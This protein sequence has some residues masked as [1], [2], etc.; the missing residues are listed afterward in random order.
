MYYDQ[1]NLQQ[2]ELHMKKRLYPDETSN[3]K[4]FLLNLLILADAFEEPY[5][6]INFLPRNPRPTLKGI[7]HY[8]LTPS[9]QIGYVYLVSAADVNEHFQSYQ[10]I[11]FIVIGEVDVSLF[12]GSSSLIVLENNCSIVDV[13]DYT[14]H[15]F[16]VYN[17]WDL[18]LQKAMVSETPLDDMLKSSLEIFQNPMFIHDTEFYILA[19]PKNVEGMTVWSVDSRTGRYMV[20][21]NVINDLKIDNEYLNTLKMRHVDMFSANQR[22]YRILYCNLWNGTRYEGRICINELQSVIKHGDYLA[23]EYLS[24]MVISCIA[25]R[26][27]FWM[28]LGHDVEQIC[29][30]ILSRQISEER[31]IRR[32][33]RFLDW[34]LEDTYLVIKLGNEHTEMD[35]RFTASAFGHIESQVSA[36]H[37]F[38]YQEGIVV[39]VNLTVSK[40]TPSQVISNLSYL[41]REGL[42]KIGVSN[43]FSNFI[44]LPDAYQQA[45]IALEYGGQSES[46]IW[47]FHFKDYALQYILDKACN[48][49]PFDFICAK[50]IK[51]LQKYDDKHNTKLNETLET[52][53]LLERNVVQTS[54]KLYIHRS[55]LFYR[56]DRIQQII[57]VDLNDPAIRLYLAISYHMSK[58]N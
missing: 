18:A 55:T 9:P 2:G 57:D 49:I 42:F 11:N 34:G 30:Q 14:L 8:R 56:L 51:D 13:F 40:T 38:F 28:G 19:C 31:E 23:L 48:D 12:S 3:G 20:P 29:K 45:S 36:S 27:S 10:D 15:I 26:N 22:G 24:K 35:Y 1:D 46:M 16:S 25:R 7:R 44:A 43:E 52:Y 41:V 21:L 54:K 6:I 32:L 53:L 33:L 39:I 50:Q 37:A 4:G 5:N 47:C 17:A 58:T